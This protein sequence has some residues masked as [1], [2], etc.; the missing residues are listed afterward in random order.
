MMKNARYFENVPGEAKN[1]EMCE[2]AVE[3]DA[4]YNLKYVPKHFL[5]K[6]L[7]SYNAPTDECVHLHAVKSGISLDFI[8]EKSRTLRVCVAAV[9]KNPLF[10]EFVPPR[11]K[12]KELCVFAIA[13]SGFRQKSKILEEFVPD[14]LSTDF[15]SMWI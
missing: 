10:L 13:R 3:K 11:F 7:A 5:G 15:W 12:S 6:L 2:Y 14:E 8:P 9:K 1:L 4:G